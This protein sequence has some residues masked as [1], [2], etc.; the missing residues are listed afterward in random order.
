M[1]DYSIAFVS[2]GSLVST[3][4]FLC[5]T[6]HTSC[7]TVSSESN[8]RKATTSGECLSRCW[9]KQGHNS[10]EVK[11]SLWLKVSQRRYHAETE[12]LRPV[13]A[14]GSWYAMH[15]KSQQ[16]PTLPP[17]CSRTRHPALRT[18]LTAPRTLGRP[19]AS[20]LSA[21]HRALVTHVSLRRPLLS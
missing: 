12:P 13:P 20:S 2:R 6:G 5:G 19:G 17:Q 3:H 18:I 10:Q 11:T 4:L 8:L 21:L 14:I 16:P 9:L 7:A 1:C 15:S